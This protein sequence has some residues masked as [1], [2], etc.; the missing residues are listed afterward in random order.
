MIFLLT[1][2]IWCGIY[3]FNVMKKFDSDD[4]QERPWAYDHTTAMGAGIGFIFHLFVAVIV[5]TVLQVV[6]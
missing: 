5:G 6:I 3:L 1:V 4:A 2:I